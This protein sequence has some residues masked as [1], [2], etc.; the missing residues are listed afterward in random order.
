MVKALLDDKRLPPPLRQR[1]IDEFFP[2]QGTAGTFGGTQRAAPKALQKLPEGR[3][4]RGAAETVRKAAPLTTGVL[5]ATQA[6]A[7]TVPRRALVGALCPQAPRV[8][9]GLPGDA[10]TDP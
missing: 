10:E 9:E 4:K 1:F 5:P 8:Q 3:V 6:A 2:E 7:E